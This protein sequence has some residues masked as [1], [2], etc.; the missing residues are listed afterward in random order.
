MVYGVQQAITLQIL[1]KQAPLQDFEYAKTIH[2]DIFPLP[3]FRKFHYNPTMLFRGDFIKN[4]EQLSR[5]PVLGEMTVSDLLSVVMITLAALGALLL[6][7]AML[8][9]FR[10]KQKKTSLDDLKVFAKKSLMSFQNKSPELEQALL[11]FTFLHKEEEK[12]HISNILFSRSGELTLYLFEFSSETHEHNKHPPKQTAILFDDFRLKLSPFSV[13]PRKMG[14]FLDNLT[15]SPD[16]TSQRFP[17]FRK[18]FRM[19][20]ENPIKTESLLT[21]KLAEYFLQNPN[22]CAEGIDNHFLI[23]EPDSQVAPSHLPD[24]LEVCLTGYHLT[25]EAASQSQ[26]T[27]ILN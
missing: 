11:P 10:L 16:I 2:D 15:G 13:R 1:Q 21:D 14:D 4:I 17:E 3:G 22:F 23:F 12:L 25:R 26:Q 8:S 9:K 7:I 27:G 19:T 20:G 6:L 24:F 5:V 18:K